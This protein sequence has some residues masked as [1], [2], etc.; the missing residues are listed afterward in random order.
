MKIDGGAEDLKHTAE[1]V[2]L[3]TTFVTVAKDAPT[4]AIFFPPQLV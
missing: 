4:N 2:P 1:L 3:C